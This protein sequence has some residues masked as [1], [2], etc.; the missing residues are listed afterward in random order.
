MR[1]TGIGVLALLATLLS[2]RAE[3]ED[4]RPRTALVFYC[5]SRW[6]YGTDIA[7]TQV[8]QA[9]RGDDV[10]ADQFLVMRRPRGLPC[11]KAHKADGFCVMVTGVTQAAVGIVPPDAVATLL[12][13]QQH[14]LAAKDAPIGLAAD[15]VGPQAWAL[16]T[17][18]SAHL[19]SSR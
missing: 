3:A 1:R 15:E 10:D 18:Y 19:G 7:D 11:V 8:A 5:Q 13:P 14:A 6:C 2:W 4:S 17:P 12:T 9:L 16:A